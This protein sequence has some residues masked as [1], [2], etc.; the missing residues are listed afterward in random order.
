MP[1]S[2][3]GEVKLSF[4]DPITLPFHPVTIT[5]NRLFP[6]HQLLLHQWGWVLD[7]KQSSLFISY[8]KLYF[9][10]WE[11]HDDQGRTG[12]TS[13]NETSD[14]GSFPAGTPGNGVPSY[15]DSGN[16]VPRNAIK[17]GQPTLGTVQKALFTPKFAHLR[18]KIGKKFSGEG[19]NPSPPHTSI[20]EPSALELSVPRVIF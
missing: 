20:L 14:Q 9:V 11:S 17:P 15:F 19:Q 13:S 10:R 2:H 4:S 12:W 18:S 3:T 5:V 16:G 7:L 8:S 1:V 6:F